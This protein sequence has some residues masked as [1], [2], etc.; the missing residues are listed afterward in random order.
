LAQAV[1]GSGLPQ[2]AIAVRSPPALAANP[3]GQPRPAAAH[4]PVGQMGGQRTWRQAWRGEALLALLAAA[5]P[6]EVLAQT[7]APTLASGLPPSPASGL[8]PTPASASTSPMPSSLMS[9][10]VLS[11]VPIGCYLYGYK[12]SPE[13]KNVTGQPFMMS[14]SSQCQ[15]KCR[16]TPGC[17]HFGYWQKSKECWLG[18]L[19]SHVVRAVTQGAVAGPA[20]CPE[21]PPACTA[22]PGP[23]YPAA[24]IQQTR[25]AWPDGEQPTNLQCWPRYTNGF[26]AKCQYRMATVLEDTAAGWPGLCDGL[27][28]ITDLMQGE[29]CQ[30]RCFQSALCGVWSVENSSNPGVPTCW[31]GMLGTNCY[32]GSGITPM[33]AQRVMHGSFRILMNTMGMQIMNLS[34]AFE[35]T[36]V[37]SVR[38]GAKRCRK[39]CLSYLFCQYWQYSKVWGCWIEDP[40]SKQVAYPL[41]NNG[42]DMTTE[43]Y[44]SDTVKAGEYLQHTC[45]PGPVISLPTDS[46]IAGAAVR[47]LNAKQAMAGQQNAHLNGRGETVEA[48]H[49]DPMDDPFAP[50]GMPIWA[51]V[52]IGF[53]VALCL[54]V[55]GVVVY[56]TVLDADKQGTRGAKLGSSPPGSSK[57]TSSSKPPSSS[58]SAKESAK[59][60]PSFDSKSS[61]FAGEST[62]FLQGMHGWGHWHGPWAHHAPPPHPAY[63][64]LPPTQPHMQGWGARHQGW[65]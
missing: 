28:K 57:S 31:Q 44:S 37:P 10:H 50:S 62:P 18:D 38:E 17:F 39:T 45:E 59:G 29:T 35:A 56:V 5:P 47:P 26:P 64:Q 51:T 52:L 3:A 9:G 61:S 49:V 30:L 41:V 43:V 42:I 21:N 23:D 58:K 13:M 24:T 16:S 48:G 54:A 20:I 46:P 19:N 53:A 65:M 27:R 2:P 8:L 34:R 63:G 12:F 32:S 36:A 6:G 33:R 60:T 14:T 55:V 25:A 1:A 7:L 11:T 40:A 15:E 22:I 4:I